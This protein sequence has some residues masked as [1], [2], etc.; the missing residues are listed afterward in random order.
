[1]SQDRVA[2][3]AK[4]RKPLENELEFYKKKTPPNKLLEQL[5][6]NDAA[7]DAQKDLLHNLESER[8]RIVA[9]YDLE[10]AR[11][12]KLWAG[13]TPGSLGSIESVASAGK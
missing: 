11:L 12:K 10:L 5:D 8:E 3:L 2:A 7:V 6:A 4:E 13:A 1:V 9:N